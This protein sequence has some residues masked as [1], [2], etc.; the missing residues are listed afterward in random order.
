MKEKLIW[1]RFIIQIVIL[2]KILL[3]DCIKVKEVKEEAQRITLKFQDH[4]L[5]P[6]IFKKAIK[7][8]FLFS[9]KNFKDTYQ[10]SD[11]KIYDC[12]CKEQVSFLIY[13]HIQGN[14]ID[15][16]HVLK[17]L[18]KSRAYNP[19]RSHSNPDLNIKKMYELYLAQCEDES[20]VPVKEKCYYKVFF[21]K[22]NLHFKQ[23]SNTMPKL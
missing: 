18:N 2:S 11:G 15:G 21:T 23:P 8:I 6:I 20:I 5:L 12:C 16:I 7:M 4:V 9:K 19:R 14:K 17:H 1:R 3:T 13:R 22:L 10:I